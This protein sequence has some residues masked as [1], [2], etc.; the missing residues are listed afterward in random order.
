MSVNLGID[1]VLKTLRLEA[2]ERLQPL[3]DEFELYYERK[4]WHQLTQS[5]EK[6]FVDDLSVN[7]RLRVYDTFVS[8]FHDK[9]NQ[10]SAVSF[11]L[12]ALEAAQL[13]K[14]EALT[15][16]QQLKKSFR[17]ID[18]KMTRN[19][20][21]KNHDDGC[22]LLDIE[23][24]RVYLFKQEMI[25]ARTQLDEISRVLDNRDKTPLMLT[26]AF[27]SANSEYF[28]QK[29]DFNNYYYT[30]LLYLSTLDA[31]AG[32]EISSEEKKKQI[33]YN[34]AI[35][36]LLGDKIYN[37]GEMLQHPILEVIA[38]D[39]QY[40]WVFELLNALSSG[41]FNKFG[42]LVK[43]QI[44]KISI[45]ADNESFLRQKICLMTLVES[46]FSRNIRI[47]SFQEISDAT[48]LPID[49]VEHLVMSAISLK[50]LKGC[51]DQVNQTVSI[52]WV[53]P[54][55]IGG[56]QVEKMRDRLVSWN[57][58]VTNLAEKMEA[59]GKSIWV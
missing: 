26:S 16:L 53:Q 32:T 40:E 12:R 5:L 36:A 37:F 9:I 59:R 34:M 7:L 23:I 42:D 11:L 41:D 14:D 31:K 13:D 48:H 25:R 45:L 49:N 39:P 58:E 3:F 20:G 6:F 52:T 15:Y 55:I 24:A 19:N 27:Y 21:M 50:L 10:L 29:S 28:K 2:D 35:A 57:Q 4:L 1:T 51:I 47:L 17:D 38:K 56:S 33:A 44:P 30:T 22:L 54:R 43:V 18:E 46:V 8:Q